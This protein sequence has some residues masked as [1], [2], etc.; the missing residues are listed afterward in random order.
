MPLL[1]IFAPVAKRYG[2]CYATPF[3]FLRVEDET[4]KTTLH[5]F[6]GVFFRGN[7]DACAPRVRTCGE[8]LS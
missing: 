6:G 1:V 7:G 3:Y 2:G 4:P 5:L 8:L